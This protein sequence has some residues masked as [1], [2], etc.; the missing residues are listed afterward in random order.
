MTI[1]VQVPPPQDLKKTLES[2]KLETELLK[3]DI[4]NAF[5]CGILLSG[6]KGY[7]I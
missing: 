7:F 6:K 1:S 2:G 3:E 4:L 5:K